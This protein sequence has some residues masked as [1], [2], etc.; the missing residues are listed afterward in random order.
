[1]FIFKFAHLT[2]T[3][4]P[5]VKIQKQLL[6]FAALFLYLYAL[7][8]TL[9]PA[10]RARSWNVDLRWSHWLGMAIWTLIVIFIHKLI[11]THAQDADP[12]LFPASALLAGWGLLTIWRLDSGFGLRQAIWLAFCS[13]IIFLGIR[14]PQNL[15]ILRRYKYIFLTSGL[16]L[17]ALTLI[18]GTNPGGP[19]LPRLWLGCCGVYI[20]P[21]E[22]LKLI[23]IIYLAAYFAD[24]I[25]MRRHLLALLFPS[26]VLTGLALAILISQKDLGTASIFIFLYSAMAYLASEKRRLLIISSAALVLAALIGYFFIDI[27]QYRLSAWI[28]PWEDPSGRSFQVIQSIMAVANGGLYGKGIGMG[29]PGLVPVAHSDFIFTS[30][31]EESGLLGSFALL[32]IMAVVT[33]RGFIVSINASSNFRRLLAAGI[34]TYFCAQSI[35]IIGGNLR[36]LPLTGVTLPFVSYGGSS[37]VTSFLGILILLLI[38]NEVDEE[39]AGLYSPQPYMNMIG[40]LGTGLLACALINGWWVQFRAEDLLSRTDNARR[41]IADRFVMRGALFDRQNRSVNITLGEPGTYTRK[42]LVPNLSSITGYTH[43][44]YGQAGLE[45]SLDGYLRGLKGNPTLLIWWNNVLYGQPPTGLNFRLS[46][47]LDI[48]RTADQ[49]LGLHTGALVLVNAKTGEILAISSHPTY[50]ANE[51]DQI[52]TSLFSSPG[53]PLLNRTTQGLYPINLSA[54]PF[55]KAAF[56]GPSPSETKLVELYKQLGFYNTPEIN[57]PSA[58]APKYGTTTG[59]KISPVQMASATASLSNLGI[60]PGLQIA[61]MVETPGQGWVSLPKSQIDT[62]CL[63]TEGAKKVAESMHD[64]DNLFWEYATGNKTENSAITWYIAG[65]LPDWSGTPLG[66]VVVLE[67]NDPTLAKEIGQSVLQRAIQP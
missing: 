5:P 7:I 62:Q 3:Y 38:S 23:L 12:Y 15:E 32:A 29:S 26:L 35:L 50:N 1:M 51:L 40:L 44:V 27:I 42:Y 9:S 56:G 39:P 63:P 46:L 11:S 45:A 6:K 13:A 52:G 17:T 36:L 43:P 8:L 58:S 16:A 53:A 21:S 30:I 18:F 37:L 22:P 14:F 28:N 24:R 49:T 64:K 33:A 55:I 60:C 41:T 66:I 61:S 10:V 47:D 4:L 67:E 59:I 31:A 2:F 54:N 57:L 48:Q 25:P 20:Q 65:T 34:S 19:G